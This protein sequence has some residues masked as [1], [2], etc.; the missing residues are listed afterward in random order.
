MPAASINL[1]VK[2]TYGDNYGNFGEANA[3]PWGFF[4]RVRHLKTSAIGGAGGLGACATVGYKLFTIP[5]YTWVQKVQAIV[6]KS[7]SATMS[8]FAIGDADASTTWISAISGTTSGCT[9]I[10]GWN[11][12]ME[13]GTSIIGASHLFMGKYYPNG[14]EIQFA[15]TLSEKTLE[16]I[17][18]VQ[19][20]TFSPV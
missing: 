12:S 10:I 3:A 17:V 18:L 8:V 6:Y 4:N 16:L 1:T 11:G 2:N 20:V 15:A 13:L 9:N 14:G 19:G 5:S 7:A